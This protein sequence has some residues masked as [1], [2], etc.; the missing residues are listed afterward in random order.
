MRAQTGSC[1]RS[2]TGPLAPQ[3]F[4]SG[5]ART[6]ASGGARTGLLRVPQRNSSG[7]PEHGVY[8]EIRLPWPAAAGA[9][10]GAPRALL[11]GPRGIP[12]GAP[13]EFLWG[14]RGV[15]LGP[16]EEASSRIPRGSGLGH[17]RGKPLE[18][19]RKSSGAANTESS[20]APEEFLWPVLFLALGSQS[21]P[22]WRGQTPPAQQ[23]L[24]SEA[25]RGS[26]AAPVQFWEYR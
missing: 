26:A 13:A 12:L 19:Q 25:L 11:W 16:P 4:A 14:S 6:A 17:A 5:V 15:P 10:S 20:G 9:S 21:F 18:R 23:A 8:Q 7:A 1:F 22:L 2:Q 3:R 24:E